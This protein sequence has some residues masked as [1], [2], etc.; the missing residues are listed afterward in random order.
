MADRYEAP[1]GV[2]RA[3]ESQVDLRQVMLK[4]LQIEAMLTAISERQLRVSD[5]FGFRR[6]QIRV[7]QRDI[8]ECDTSEE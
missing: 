4:L 5:G 2:T 6:P 1:E 8:E 7:I 3:V